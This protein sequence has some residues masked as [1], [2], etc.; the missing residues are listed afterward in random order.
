MTR[1][2]LRESVS[3][4][5]VLIIEDLHWLALGTFFRAWPL[6]MQGQRSEGIAQ[7]RQGLAAWRA[8][9]AEFIRPYCLALLA[10]AH[11]QSGQ[12][13]EG[14]AV[15]AEALEAVETTG[16]RFYEAE[17]H[18][19][20]GALL[21]PSPTQRAAAEACFH[22]ALHIARRQGA[23]SLELRAAMSLARLWQQQGQRAA[24]HQV[25]APIYN[26]FTEGFETADLQGAKGLSEE[27]G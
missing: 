8:I 9:G 17:L 23:K 6:V 10:E 13:E 21:L 24:A 14:L 20:R 18:R 3:Q 7:M 11:A 1:L 4:P 15:V 22:Q 27:L 5:V 26:W 16:E 2:V 12:A 19:L 25:L